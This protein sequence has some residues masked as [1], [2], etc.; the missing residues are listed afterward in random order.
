[1]PEA[2]DRSAAAFVLGMCVV[3]LGLLCSEW[4]VARTFS[5]DGILQGRT[6]LYVRVVSFAIIGTGAAIIALHRRCNAADALAAIARRFPRLTAL[7]A[8]CGLVLAG[9]V[10]T[11]AVFYSLNGRRAL[12]RRIHQRY[13]ADLHHYD[14]LLAF[15]AAPNSSVT[16][17]MH[18]NDELLFEATY[19]FD[20]FSRR[21]VPG[22]EHAAT[23]DQAVVFFGGS[24]V[25][26]GACEDDGTL[27]YYLSRHAPGVAVH[28]YGFGGYG[29]GQM[30]AQ[31]ESGEVA[32]QTS[33]NRP[34]AAVYVYIPGHIKRAVGSMHVATKWGRYFPCYERG[35]EG[36]YVLQGSFQSAHPVRMWFYDLLAR[37]QVMQYLKIDI[38]VTAA[39]GHMRFTAGLINAARRS[40]ERQFK[41]DRFY[42]LIYPQHPVGPLAD[43]I[44]PYLEDEGVRCL[45]YADL[46]DLAQPG[47]LVKVDLHPTAKAH[48]AMA[49]RLAAD[50]ALGGEGGT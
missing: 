39:P 35:E 44:V 7:S 43:A 31:L 29:P 12:A 17:T 32:D 37:D 28:N 18:C 41:S 5:P 11:E 34:T 2:R 49:P 14:P 42:V 23:M 25:F 33:P 21:S 24:F 30:L 16:E 19:T 1:M 50:L 8:G 48:A 22:M 27:P 10:L 4:V 38:P 3:C 47:Y 26:G 36:A 6:L 40:F 15:R 9:F 20:E 45:N 46:I 13:S